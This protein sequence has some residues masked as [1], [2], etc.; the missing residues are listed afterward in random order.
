ML[1]SQ[2][3]S[4]GKSQVRSF[5]A[6]RKLEGRV[7]VHHFHEWCGEQLRTYHVEVPH[8]GGQMWD[9]QVEAVMIVPE[10]GG[11]SGPGPAFR[12]FESISA[13]IAYAVKC[14]KAWHE[15][16]DF[17]GDIAVI[18]MKPDHG[19]RIAHQLQALGIPHHL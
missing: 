7:N 8:D 6:E 12:Q 1:K 17:L 14:L 19:K 5:I 9:R 18:C 13:E 16:G 2:G 4:Q 11:T 3:K 15:R 10:T